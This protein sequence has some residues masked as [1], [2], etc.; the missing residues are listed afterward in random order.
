MH[1]ENKNVS[2]SIF[3]YEIFSPNTFVV[4]L[5]LYSSK[6]DI[7]AVFIIQKSFS[8]KITGLYS[9]ITSL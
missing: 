4:V 6:V 8:V 9:Q 2:K 7:I 1:F 3:F 5:H